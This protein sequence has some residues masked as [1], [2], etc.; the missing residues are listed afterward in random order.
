MSNILFCFFYFLLF[1]VFILRS[2]WFTIEGVNNKSFLFVFYL[3]LLFGVGLWFIYTHIYKNRTTSDI[4]K[5]FD[6]AKMIFDTLHTSTK[7][8]FAMLTGIGDSDA[9][10]QFIYHS[11]NS[12]DNAHNNLFYTNSH[13]IIR[14]NAFFLL[15]S[16]GCYGVHI[17]F[18]CFI[19]LVGL[20]YIYKTFVLFIQSRRK[21]LFAAIFLFPSVILWSSG[22]LKEGLVWFALGLS[23]YHFFQLTN[24]NTRR[25]KHII[26]ILIGFIL[27]FELKAY[28]LLCLLPG[29]I[30][31]LLIKKIYFLGKR[32]VLSYIVAITLLLIPAFFPGVFSRSYNPLQMLSDKQTD[33]NRIS[34]GGIYL[35]NI[36][37]SSDYAVIAT[38]DSSQIV[39]LNS[40]AD[41]L[42]HKKGIQYLASNSFCHY[43]CA[44]QHKAPF[45][46]RKG[47]P[48]AHVRSGNIDTLR[49]IANDSTIYL[50]YIYVETAKS[51]IHIE[52]IQPNALSLIRNIPQALKVSMLLP[53]PWQLHS[54]MTTI[55]CAENIFVLLLLFIALFFIKRPILHK[56][57][58]LFCLSYC[59]MMLILIG[60]VTPILGGIERYK[61][62][63]IPF[64]FILLLLI[65]QK[66]L[67]KADDK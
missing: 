55:Y 16:H 23:I 64:I 6:D 31:Q 4:F 28:V 19:A 49:E 53:Y 59:V 1:S 33:F 7:D 29:L 48:F 50:L 32:P 67:A 10:Y 8:Y 65:T 36:K 30:A 45:M 41:S 21:I 35:L 57:L 47:T 26:W 51:R 18:M 5:Y 37:D 12:W 15:F 9:H 44:S 60:L 24:N 11:M 20:T 54:A 22:I 27:L 39:P 56:D 62:V 61:S 63:V 40:W 25:W 43:E 52:P 58:A 2:K 42:L 14:L 46:L 34:S 66:P 38:K 17:I 13:F 3:K